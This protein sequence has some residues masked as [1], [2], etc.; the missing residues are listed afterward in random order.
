[1]SVAAFGVTPRG[2]FSLAESAGFAFTDRESGRRAPEL[3]IA[4]CHDDT[5][6]PTGFHLTQAEPDGAVTVDGDPEARGQL[7]RVLGLDVDATDFARVG[8]RDPVVAALQAAA[9]GLRP[10]AL[11]SAYEAAAW[12]VLAARRTA[13]Q[14]RAM[15]RHLAEQAGT[16]LVIAGK[17]VVC[18]PPPEALLSAAPVP[19]L[20]DVRLQRLWGVAQAALEGRLGTLAL[21]A[22]DPEEARTRVQELAGIGPFS[23]AIIVGRG[24]GHTDVLFGPVTELNRHVGRLY[25]LG[26]DAT[27]DEL[28][29]IAQGWSPW[30]AWVQVYFRAVSTRPGYLQ[31]G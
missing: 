15:R 3:R 17:P 11:P 10:P 13:A 9:P 6:E 1:V 16:V 12:C 20:D 27:P 19:G 8:A 2:P 21:K 23:S 28:G 14:A 7:E 4:F 22:L 25:R 30:R 26:H 31:A 29:Q 18:L 5:F 24:L